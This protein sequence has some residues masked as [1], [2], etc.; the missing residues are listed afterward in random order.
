MGR[1]HFSHALINHVKLAIKDITDDLFRGL[2]QF[3]Y[4][5]VGRL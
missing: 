2:K 5:L 4:A 1:K 3:V